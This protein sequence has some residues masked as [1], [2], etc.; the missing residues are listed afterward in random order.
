MKNIKLLCNLVL[1]YSGLMAVASEPPTL[2]G[3]L[4]QSTIRET[5]SPH[6]FNRELGT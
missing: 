4:K 1:F 6:L 2:E 3:I 5:L